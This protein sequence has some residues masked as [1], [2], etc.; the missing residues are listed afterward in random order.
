MAALQ[1]Q[2]KALQKAVQQFAHAELT[3]SN[4]DSATPCNSMRKCGQLSWHA[5]AATCKHRAVTAGLVIT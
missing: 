3:K 5:P 1:L 2:S 4:D